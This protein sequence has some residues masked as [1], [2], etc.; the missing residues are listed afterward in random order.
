[1]PLP[2]LFTLFTTLLGVA[3]SVSKARSQTTD[4]AVHGSAP[5]FLNLV[6][7][8]LK[9]GRGTARNALETQL[10]SDFT[11][12][13]IPAYWLEAERSGEEI[14]ALNF[15][16]S[17]EEFEKVVTGLAAGYADHP[18]ILGKVDRML[19]ENITAVNT[20]FTVRRDDLGY[21]A[22]AVD[23]S[24]ARILWL[25]TFQVRPGHEAEFAEATRAAS[26]A[27]EKLGATTPWVVYEVNDGLPSPSFVLLMPLRSLSELGEAIATRQ[28]IESANEASAVRLQE[29]A[30]N[31]YSSV[32][33]D[34]FYINP[35]CSHLPED[36]TSG[37]PDFWTAKPEPVHSKKPRR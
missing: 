34:I 8:Q 7:E 10:V 27:H 15:V 4:S 36:F 26:I 32:K 13:N 29:I 23:F 21:R 19:Q 1:M 11:Q 28:Q 6:R 24:K 22:K 35:R 17:F 18:E 33:T 20:V 14:F 30:R 2:R 31:A 9:P 12:A 25:T 37:D 16:N 3:A 5:K